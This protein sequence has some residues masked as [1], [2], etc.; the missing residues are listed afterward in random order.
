ML[1]AARPPFT[2]S[3]S[4]LFRAVVTHRWKGCGKT[5]AIA[6]ATQAMTANTDREF[7]SFSG[8]ATAMATD[9]P[10]EQID[11]L[12]VIIVWIC[13]GKVDWIVCS[14]AAAFEKLGAS[15]RIARSDR[16]AGLSHL[17]WRSF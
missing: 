14:T 13:Y 11:L 15:W 12:V 8:R 1:M 6:D 3:S 4:L 2:G 7:R 16:V 5:S 17:T 10:I 9:T